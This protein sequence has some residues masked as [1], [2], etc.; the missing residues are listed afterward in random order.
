M[1]ARALKAGYTFAKKSL[2]R[3]IQRIACMCAEYKDV[4]LSVTPRIPSGRTLMSNCI[5]YNGSRPPAT[6]LERFIRAFVGL[7]FNYTVQSG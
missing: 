3:I 6:R 4:L 1:H 5:N 2:D 7:M